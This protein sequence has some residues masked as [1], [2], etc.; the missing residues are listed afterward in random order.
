MGIKFHYKINDDLTVDVD[1]DVNIS[2]KYLT[3]IPIQ[4]GIVIGSFECQSN[5]LTSLKGCP[6]KVGDFMGEEMGD[7][8]YYNPIYVRYRR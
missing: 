5:N 6:T 1:T 8:F 7:D 4:F 3:N 2:C